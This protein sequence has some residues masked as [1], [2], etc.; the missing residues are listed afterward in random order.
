[1]LSQHKKVADLRAKA[2]KAE[3]DLIVDRAKADRDRAS[4]AGESN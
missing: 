4:S 3:R 2:D 1:M